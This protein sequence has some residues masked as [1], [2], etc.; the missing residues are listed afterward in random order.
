MIGSQLIYGLGN[1]MSY[2]AGNKA[3]NDIFAI[4]K[5]SG[6]TKLYYI[7]RSANS[8]IRLSRLIMGLMTCLI[9]S[10]KILLQYPITN[11]PRVERF[12]INIFLK[13]FKKDVTIVVHDLNTY[14]FGGVL[15][16]YEIKA[17]KR[18][19]NLL[20]H[21][22]AMKKFLT[23]YGIPENKMLIIG[24]FPYLIEKRNSIDR[25]K[26]NEIVFAG[27]LDKSYFLRYI[28]NF[29]SKN[30]IIFNLYGTKTNDISFNERVKYMGRFSPED[31]SNLQG[32][33]GLVW[34]GDSLDTC[35]GNLGQYMR[36]NSPHKVS[37]YIAAE[38][39]IIIWSG[40][41]LASYVINNKL[42]IA[43]DSFE[44]LNDIIK[45]MSQESYQQLLDSI[46]EFSS[47]ITTGRL[48]KRLLQY[49]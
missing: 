9:S 1:K 38:L 24:A 37:L 26:N 31:V 12:L 19:S 43:V 17:L 3:V 11:A 29:A 8:F 40:S 6:Y 49:Q 39:P 16:L 32:K 25:S 23:K 2:N 18:A 7:K 20:I 34:D 13:I 33:W 22:H 41:A 44:E 47:N 15:D 35:S 10:E 36:I 27:N 30:N 46:R 42:G 48:L 45:N 28:S 21:T 14:R 5:E 4:A